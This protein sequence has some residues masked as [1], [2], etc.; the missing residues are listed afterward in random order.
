MF[1][2]QNP[3]PF[4]SIYAAKS[5]PETTKNAPEDNKKTEKKAQWKVL[6]DAAAAADMILSA[7]LSPGGLFF[8][9]C[10]FR[11]SLSSR[12]KSLAPLPDGLIK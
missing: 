9:A 12:L 1:S 2:E 5:D 11:N 3:H 7:I 6:D 8:C 4:A 10:S